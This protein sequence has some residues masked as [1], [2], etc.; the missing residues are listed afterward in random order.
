MEYQIWIKDEFEEKY[1]KVD[2]GDM[3]AAKRELQKALLEGK[4]PLLTAAIPYDFSIKVDES[5]IGAALKVKG[6]KEPAEEVKE[7]ETEVETPPS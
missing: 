7:K 2:C 3:A 1:T 5:K 4:D 6:K